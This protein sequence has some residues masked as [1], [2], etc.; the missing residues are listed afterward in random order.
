ML[1]QL[2]TDMYGLKVIVTALAIAL[3]LV[4]TVHIVLT[5]RNLRAAIG[6]IGVVWLAP[7][8]GIILYFILIR[9]K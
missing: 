4:A 5:K 2:P 7:Y 8:L 6:W 9:K 1:D 3:P